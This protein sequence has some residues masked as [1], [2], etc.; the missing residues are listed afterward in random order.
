MTKLDS[1]L[2]GVAGEYFVAGELTLR[3]YLASI[4]LRNT[5]GIDVVVSNQDATHSASVQV[6]T[7]SSGQP[8]WILSKKAESL[9][10]DNHYYVFVALQ[11][12]GERPAYYVV[13]SQVVA[14]YVSTSHRE[15]LQGT[16]PDGTARKDSSIRAFRDERGEYLERWDIIQNALEPAA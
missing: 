2:V 14:E 1:T 9:Y 8:K 12:V 15:W 3:G 16:K 6:K 13:P 11:A 10:S 4:T 7:N 5:R